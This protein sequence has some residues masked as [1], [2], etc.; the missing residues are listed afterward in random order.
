MIQK[1]LLACAILT[2]NIAAADI[3]DVAVD[4]V[5]IH[6]LVAQVMGDL[7]APDLVVTPGASPHGYA[8]RPSQA[9]ALDQADLVIWMGAPLTPWLENPLA[10]LA[11]DAEQLTLLEVPG[12][13]LHEVRDGIA[14]E[15]DDHSHDH[16]HAIDPHAWLDPENA[17]LWLG[18]I[19]DALADLD[20]E[21]AQTYRQ[22]AEMAQSDL[23]A[24]IEQIAAQLAPLRSSRF[25]VF[26]DAY[27]YFEHRFDITVIGAISLT[28]ASDPGAARITEIR[29][30][31]ATEGVSCVFSEP[32]FNA[33]LIS[34]VLDGG[35]ANTAV[36]DPIGANIAPG[37]DFYPTL[38]HH[39]ADAI[40]GCL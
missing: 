16:D 18:I 29:N 1:P 36:I 27:Q 12:T 31:V 32:Q 4:I 17:R 14:F 15:T 19:A 6:G 13:I 26:H 33:G 28:D 34:A 37:P 7:G 38:M 23:T 8:L 3:P 20:P 9:R 39:I 5:P 10:S 35:D 21:N 2:A 30:L 25:I 24:I 11:S 40:D 22:N